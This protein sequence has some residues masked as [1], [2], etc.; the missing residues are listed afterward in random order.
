MLRHGLTFCAFILLSSCDLP[1]GAAVQSEITA[2]A[3]SANP[4]VALYH[5]NR[6][7]LAEIQSWPRT[8]TVRNHGWLRHHHQSSA[9]LIAAGDSLNI[10]IWDSEEASLLSNRAD[11]STQMKGVKVSPTGSVFLPFAGEVRVSGLSE[12]KA[13]EKIQ[14][15]MSE[16]VPSAQV[17][18]TVVKGNAGSV[19][20]LSGV[21]RPGSYPIE[22]NH[23]TVL[24]ALATA[25]GAL[26]NIK[27]PQLRLIRGARVYTKSYATLLENPSLD[28][29]LRGKDK[30]SV[31]EDKRYFR[32]LGAASKEAIV[33]FT[34]DQIFAL[35][36][37]SMIG[38]LSE[39]R[40]DPKGIMVLRQ[41]HPNQVRQDSSGPSNPR[42]VFVFDLTSAD[43]L[44]SAGEF[45]IQSED[46][47]L[48]TEAEIASASIALRVLAQFTGAAVDIRTLAQ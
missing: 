33:P 20:V 30:L 40:A 37:M 23:T 7:R 17:Q 24:N 14:D 11:S 48:V 5:V 6:E 36:A 19:S 1:R 43:G 10:V 2:A 13:R 27:N 3:E 34:K 38:G 8:D 47:V 31:E 35:D 21:R 15:K 39:N 28:T 25:G 22:D 26:P 32:S 29:N 44:F 9:N 18:L 45:E 4:E 42:T 46:T 16:V 12:S 41:Y